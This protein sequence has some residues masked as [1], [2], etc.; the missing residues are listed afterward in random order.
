LPQ[1]GQFALNLA[2][3]QLSFRI[4]TLPCRYGGWASDQQ[5]PLRLIQRLAEGR[6]LRG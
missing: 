6:Q 3:R 5:Q 4:A 1:D 2:G